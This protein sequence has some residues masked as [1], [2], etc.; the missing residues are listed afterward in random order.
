MVTMEAEYL[1]LSD[2]AK[3][4]AFFQNFHSMFYS[5]ICPYLHLV[6]NPVL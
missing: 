5:V 3:E 2:V 6:S 4:A 1:G